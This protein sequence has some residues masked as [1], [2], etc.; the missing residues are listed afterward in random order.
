[1]SERLAALLEASEFH[2]QGGG[3]QTTVTLK[4]VLYHNSV[5]ML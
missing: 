2:S 3:T 1:M 5:V 4:T